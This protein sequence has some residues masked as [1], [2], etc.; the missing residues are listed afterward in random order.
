MPFAVFPRALLARTFI[1]PWG[2]PGPGGQARGGL[3][4]RHI[5]PDFRH[6]HFC[7][8]W[9]IPGIVSK[10][11]TARGKVRGAESARDGALRAVAPGNGGWW[12][13]APAPRARRA[14][15]IVVLGVEQA[16]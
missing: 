4:P 10:R 5:N 6:G 12:G 15:S 1:I 11:S 8:P 3:K 16:V 2:Y 14:V 13:S 7:P 9:S